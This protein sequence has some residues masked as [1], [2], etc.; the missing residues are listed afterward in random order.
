MKNY[1]SEFFELTSFL[2]SFQSSICCRTHILIASSTSDLFWASLILSVSLVR[3][4]SIIAWTNARCD[5]GFIGLKAKFFAVFSNLALVRSNFSWMEV[6]FASP[7]LRLI[8]CSK[9]SSWGHDSHSVAFGTSYATKDSL[10]ICCTSGLINL[11]RS[12]DWRRLCYNS[13][14]GFNFSIFEYCKS[15]R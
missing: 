3:I 5:A 4:I 6:T 13:T 2:M 7:P 11:L 15:F 14:K 10:M 8:N 9:S 12:N 1:G